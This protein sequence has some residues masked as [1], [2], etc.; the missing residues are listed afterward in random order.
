MLKRSIEAALN[1]SIP[2]H[3]KLLHSQ[4]QRFQRHSAK[5]AQVHDFLM[6]RLLNFD[7]HKSN[8]DFEI[9]AI[10]RKENILSAFLSISFQ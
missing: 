4:S 3:S 5:P 9:A 7:V 2:G 1:M 6:C 10:A 8:P